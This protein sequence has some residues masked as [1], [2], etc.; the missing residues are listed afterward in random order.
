MTTT[1]QSDKMNDYIIK[2]LKWPKISHLVDWDFKVNGDLDIHNSLGQIIYREQEDG[3]CNRWF[4]DE[5]GKNYLFIDSQGYWS[6]NYYSFDGILVY[7]F[8]SMG[9]EDKLAPE[10]VILKVKR[11][12]KI[13]ELLDD[14]IYPKKNR[15][16]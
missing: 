9:V 16:K 12:Y 5:R 2:N 8:D 4:W 1:Q 14:K 3:L 6:R 7:S 10:P 15:K 11:D 13:R